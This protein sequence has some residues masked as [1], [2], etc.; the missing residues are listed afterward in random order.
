M[1]DVYLDTRK[2]FDIVPNQRLKEVDILSVAEK[3][4]IGADER[5]H[6]G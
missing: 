3:K 6:E 4:N 2:A 5:L 1:N